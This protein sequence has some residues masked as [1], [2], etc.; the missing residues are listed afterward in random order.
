VQPT[1]Y[2]SVCGG[3]WGGGGIA[4]DIRGVCVWHIVWL[5]VEFV[6]R[7][8]RACVRVR[9]FLRAIQSVGRFLLCMHACIQ[10]ALYV[11]I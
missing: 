3:W 1:Q 7:K 8:K 10:R 6:K 4:K 9:A 11:C 5:R 2:V